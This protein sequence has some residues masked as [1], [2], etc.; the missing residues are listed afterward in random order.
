MVVLTGEDLKGIGIRPR[1][2]P[3]YRDQP[4]LAINRVRYVGEPVAVVAATDARL[5]RA[6]AAEIEVE[7]DELPAVF[8]PEDALAADAII[9]HE[10][11]DE[12][13]PSFADIVLQGRGSRE[14]CATCSPCA[15]AKGW[16]GSALRTGSSRTSSP[17]RRFSTCRWSRMRPWRCSRSSGLT[18]MTCTQTPYAVRDALAHMFDMPA[19]RVRV[20]VP[21]V[22]GG[23][24]GKTYAKVEPVAALVARY[25]GRRRSS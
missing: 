2:G 7:Y 5:A 19:S 9:L 13:G 12:R 17:R 3:V 18:V 14:T 16:T 23:F 21:P 24:G 20:I 1:F 11:S 4:V 10:Q 8:D 15:T 22:G 25:A 6:A